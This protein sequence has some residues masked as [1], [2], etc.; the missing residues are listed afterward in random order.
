K[1]L[2]ALGDGGAVVTSDPT[3]AERSRL[4]R[5]YGWRE[6][7]ISELAGMNSRLDELQAAVLRVKLRHLDRENARRRE[8]A[9][10]YDGRLA[11]RSI[12]LPHSRGAMEHVYHQYVVRS[13]QR[14]SLKAFLKDN[15][16][17]VAIHYPAPVHLQ[18]AYRSRIAA[19]N[20]GLGET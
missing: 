4:L 14:E 9:R 13:R 6:R 10:V 17:G 19:A 1:N 7:Y 8:I 3:L 20:G 16:I 5:E 2:G 12:I 11:S 15:A 18:P